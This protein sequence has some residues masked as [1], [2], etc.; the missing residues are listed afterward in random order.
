MIWIH[1]YLSEANNQI[2]GL[3]LDGKLPTAAKTIK[4]IDKTV[5]LQVHLDVQV[6]QVHLKANFH[7]F[8]VCLS[9]I[10]PIYEP[11]NIRAGKR[12]C[13]LIFLGE[14]CPY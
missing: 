7:P 6:V 10:P 12:Y 2:T 5:N 8:P 11:V 13:D 1:Y 14:E 3:N 4:T 9:C